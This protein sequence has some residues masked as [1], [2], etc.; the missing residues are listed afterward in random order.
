[1]G[2]SALT[3]KGNPDREAGKYWATQRSEERMKR[4]RDLENS[5]LFVG[6]R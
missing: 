2:T 5:S 1:M 6:I 4:F 3:T